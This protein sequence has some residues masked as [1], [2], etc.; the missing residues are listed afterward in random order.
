MK[1]VALSDTHNTHE[2]LDIPDGDLLIHAGDFSIWGEFKEI[3]NFSHWMVKQ[4]HPYKLVIPGNHDRYC[5]GMLSFCKELFAPVVFEEANVIT[6]AGL[7]ILCY[8][9]TPAPNPN[10]QWKFHP[11]YG[12]QD[13]FKRFW[14][15]APPPV[16]IL[17]THG[18]PQGILDRVKFTHPG[19]DPNV[20]EYYLREYVKRN[21]PRLHLFGHIHEQYGKTTIGPTTFYN[22]CVCDDHYDPINPVT[23]IDL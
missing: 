14:E 2:E 11:E 20:G 18:P 21:P 1:I 19:E 13:G 9:W 17:V 7:R 22:L 6:L 23:I 8:S 3:S 5:E 10:S 4:P 12:E 16:D 15:C